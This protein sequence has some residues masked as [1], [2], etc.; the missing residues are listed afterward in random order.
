MAKVRKIRTRSKGRKRQSQRRQPSARTAAAAANRR[1][2]IRAKRERRGTDE[3]KVIA[4]IGATP[5]RLAKGGRARKDPNNRAK[6]Q[7]SAP[8]VALGKGGR[9]RSARLRRRLA[10]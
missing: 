7:L 4:K 5:R 1:H 6:S 10:A 8:R 3:G 9:P 2:D